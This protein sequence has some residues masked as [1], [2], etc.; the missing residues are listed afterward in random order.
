[1]IKYKKRNIKL[2]SNYK[3]KSLQFPKKIPKQGWSHT[4]K[5][6]LTAFWNPSAEVG[7]KSWKVKVIRETGAW[8]TKRTQQVD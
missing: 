7:K 1:M 5:S 2:G 3:V 6:I 4:H 8:I